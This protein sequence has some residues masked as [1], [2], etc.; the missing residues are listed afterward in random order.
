MDTN[1]ITDMVAS[2]FLKYIT[3]WTTS[4]R[5]VEETPSTPGQWDLAKALVAELRGLGVEEVE[6]TSNCYVIARL[7]AGA[8]KEHCPAIGFMAHLDTA[9][10]VSGKDVRAVFVESY[11]GK[12]IELAEGRGLDPALDPDLARQT[13][14]AIIHTDGATLL[15]ADDKAGIAAIM[16]A[17]E[18]LLAHPEIERGPVELIFTPD[19]ETG[20]GL[21]AFPLGAVR[22]AVCYTLDGGALGEVEAECFNAYKA[23][24]RFGGTV[25]HL[26]YARGVMANAAL[27]AASFA[28]MLPRSESPEAT[29]GYYGYY[30][31]TN[32]TGNLERATLECYVRDFDPHGAERRVAALE[33]FA[34]AVEAQF[35]GGTVTVS[36]ALQYS[37]MKDAV[38]KR[39][40]AMDTLKRA[41]ANLDIPFR[42]RPIRG[43]TDGSRLT[44]MG[45]PTPNIF[46]GG[47]NWHSRTE[48]VSV[49]EMAAACRVVVE[50]VRLWALN[51]ITAE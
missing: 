4:D 35:P 51:P 45:I 3:Y 24:V 50:L 47:R 21:P 32:I 29:D 1:A 25:A 40:E 23:T 17:A 9:D 41:L 43:G 13:G 39:P 28:L 34:R 6:L 46:T 33:C 20:K 31:P 36:A 7:G 16:S 2:R 14:T 42:L 10:D 44:E 49:P 12:R 30:C 8:G 18:Y 27:M 11:D 26:G 48:W 22:A 37:N 38:A 5:T 19:E 15:G